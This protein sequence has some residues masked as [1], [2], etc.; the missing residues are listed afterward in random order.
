M[1]FTLDESDKSQAQRA[2]TWAKTSLSIRTTLLSLIHC[3]CLW[4]L[5]WLCFMVSEHTG[6]M[7]EHTV[8]HS[9]LLRHFS[10]GYHI[11][12]ATWTDMPC[13]NKLSF[14]FL[15]KQPR[16]TNLILTLT[17]SLFS[18]QSSFLNWLA[19]PFFC[20]SL[21]DWLIDNISNP[22][23]IEQMQECLCV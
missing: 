14:L 4:R 3:R 1:F 6:R 18:F 16:G 19:L 21:I 12:S 23:L 20:D 15:R 17:V 9:L 10:L 5:V 2:T 11:Y 7:K 22:H 13:S 8:P